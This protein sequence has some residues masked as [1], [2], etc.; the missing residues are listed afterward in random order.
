[1]FYKM[2]EYLIAM[3]TFGAGNQYATPILEL[4]SAYQGFVE[5]L[6]LVLPDSLGFRDLSIRT[7]EIVVVT[8]SG[9]FLL[10]E[11]SGGLMVLVDLCW[12]L[13]L[14]SLGRD[15]FVVAM[16]EPENHLHPS[17]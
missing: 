10:D 13:H 15:R 14:Y 5:V 11:A 9:D 8:D 12:R 7:P 17:M 1:P 3:A 2:K 16:D 4:L 6:R